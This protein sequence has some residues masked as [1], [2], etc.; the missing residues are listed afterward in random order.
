MTKTAPESARR[1]QQVHIKFNAYSKD[2]AL[3]D[4]AEIAFR[5]GGEV[6]SVAR[7]QFLGT[8]FA[9][10]SGPDNMVDRIFRRRLDH[11]PANLEVVTETGPT[12]TLW[13]TVR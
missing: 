3:L 13:A 6:V 5:S 12:T 4:T 8:Y 7:G 10:L 2:E 11:R 1:M 9:T